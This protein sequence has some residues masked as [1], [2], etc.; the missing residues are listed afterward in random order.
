M[1]SPVQALPVLKE[2]P[3]QVL[4]GVWRPDLSGALAAL[5]QQKIM[6]FSSALATARRSPL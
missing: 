2:R 3:R 1:V 5:F 4:D 6:D